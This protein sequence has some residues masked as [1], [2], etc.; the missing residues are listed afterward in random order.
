MDENELVHILNTIVNNE[1]IISKNIVLQTNT[2]LTLS[3]LVC[4]IEILI[5][6]LDKRI[7]MVE[8]RVRA[9]EGNK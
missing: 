9:L 3:K 2:A 6:Q 8:K 7:D 5:K 1:N 4:G